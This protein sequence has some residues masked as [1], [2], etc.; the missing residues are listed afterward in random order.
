MFET[1]LAKLDPARFADFASKHGGDVVR[2]QKLFADQ[3]GIGCVKCHAV[4]GSGGNIG[5]DL[6]GV[7]ARYPRAELIRSVLEPSNRI[8][9]G[10]E[11]TIVV[12]TTGAIHQGI[13]KSQTP[14]KVVLLT[15][16]GETREIRTGDIDEQRRSNLS[17]MPIGLTEGMTLQDFSDIIAYLESL[18]A[19]GG[20]KTK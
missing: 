19:K 14:D 8:V 4:S 16:E 13:V 11:L 1:P 5:P 20:P 2:G 12:T 17:P 7:G 18:K 10:Y 9:D 3:K 15:P 6:G